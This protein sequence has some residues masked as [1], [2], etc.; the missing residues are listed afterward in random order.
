MIAA[1]VG[2]RP[3]TLLTA[4]VIHTALPTRLQPELLEMYRQLS[5][6]WQSWNSTYYEHY[7]RVEVGQGTEDVANTLEGHKQ[8][9]TN[10]T[11]PETGGRNKRQPSATDI[12]VSR[13]KRKAAGTDDIG[14]A[15]CSSAE[16]TAAELPKRFIYNAEYQ[17]MICIACASIMQ[18]GQ[19]S[20]NSHL[21]GQH[22]IKGPT[23]K[24]YLERLCQ[25]QLRS[26]K[27]FSVPQGVVRAI[28]SLRVYRAFRCNFC[29]HRTTRWAK[30]L[31]H[32]STHKL[33]VSPR[34]AWE[35]GR[36]SKCHVQIFSS[37][38][39]LIAYFDVQAL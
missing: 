10:L 13:K 34:K 23:C 28:Q 38:P 31:D 3:R 29:Q 8:C 33:G 19:N 21:N 6:L 26:F 35:M 9:P 17:I 30:I 1:G 11:T 16:T 15:N 36:I 12:G 2:H 18:L 39:G 25:L 37:A 14:Y 20:L 5:T 27:E 32:V 22:G 24:A 7:C 4:Y